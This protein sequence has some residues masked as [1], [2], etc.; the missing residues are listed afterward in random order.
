MNLTR[1][2]IRTPEDLEFTRQ[3]I[4]QYSRAGLTKEEVLQIK[5]KFDQ[6]DI[7]KLNSLIKINVIVELLFYIFC[8][9]SILLAFVYWG[10]NLSYEAQIR[11]NT[12]LI[13]VSVVSLFLLA[14]IFCVHLRYRKFERYI[15]TEGALLSDFRKRSITWLG[16]KMS[17]SWIDRY[18]NNITGAV[19]FGA[20]LLVVVVGLRGLGERIMDL[21]FPFPSW[22]VAKDG[23]KLGVIFVA[24]FIEFLLLVILATFTFFKDEEKQS[25]T[26]LS[27]GGSLA[28]I[29]KLLYRIE[30]NSAEIKTILKKNSCDFDNILKIIQQ[31]NKRLESIDYKTEKEKVKE[32]LNELI[33]IFEVRLKEIVAV[34]GSAETEKIKMIS[35]SV[36]LINQSVEKISINIKD[37]ELRIRI[38][39]FTERMLKIKNVLGMKI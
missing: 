5:A 18:E 22:L 8:F 34:L 24:L 11:D 39:E 10:W 35:E 2:L 17:T 31:I 20:G 33:V 13:I 12:G 29:E 25:E 37:P 16:D 7:N 26:N 14:H 30:E 1:H 36:V 19:Y 28:L 3:N 6:L 23:L 15:Q 9:L 27:G 21:G 32:L 4:S 38:D